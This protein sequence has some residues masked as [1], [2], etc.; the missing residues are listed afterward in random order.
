[1][2]AVA[3]AAAGCR[4]STRVESGTRDEVLHIGNGAEPSDVDPGPIAAEVE[5]TIDSALF[6]GLVNIANDGLTILPGVAESWKISADGKVYTF[7]LR[8]D[9]CWSDG[10]PLTADDFLYA[11]RRVFTPSMACQLAYTGFDIAGSREFASGRNTSPES[12]GLRALGPYTFEVR[13]AQR[14]P[15]MLFVL[16]G[17]PFEPVPRAVVE[18]FGGGTRQGSAWTRPGNLV[19][20]GAFM[21]SSWHPNLDLVA[22]RNPHYWDRAR[23]RLREVHFY[24]MDDPDAEELAF[25]AGEL[26]VTFSLPISK[27]AAYRERSDPQLHV[28]PLLSSS[29]LFFNTRK[30][31]FADARVRRAFSLAIDRDRLIPLVLHESASPAHSLTRP[32]TG[33]YSPPPAADYDPAQARRML[34][35]AGYPGGAGLPPVEFRFANPR[36]GPLVEALQQVWQQEIGVRVSVAIEEQKTF[37]SDA[38]EGNYQLGMMGYSYSFNAPE[39]I[40]TLPL[41]DSQSNYTGWRDPAFERAYDRASNAA[42]DAGRRAG[43]DE[44]ERI[45]ASEAPFAPLYYINQPYLVSTQVRGW[46]DNGLA[47]VDWREL[48]L[49]P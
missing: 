17:A 27:V 5:Y 20:N 2:L 15:N 25:R 22:V 42:T 47:Q 13:L 8:P 14:Q 39:A 6:E 1:M 12:L 24:P 46:R 45:L 48:S 37:F 31:P 34:A 16:G 38:V 3:I 36:S 44:M 29:Y 10:S 23:V 43:F 49:V 21:L 26:H 35:E 19:S 9:A 7:S 18:R 28:N 4:H 33:G 11:F 32:G 40:L 41:G 30:P